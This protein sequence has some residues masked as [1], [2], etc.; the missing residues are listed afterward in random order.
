[1]APTYLPTDNWTV[2]WKL[3]YYLFGH[4]QFLILHSV[5]LSQFRLFPFPFFTYWNLSPICCDLLFSVSMYLKVSAELWSQ[6]KEGRTNSASTYFYMYVCDL[7]SFCVY[8]SNGNKVLSIWMCCNYSPCL[9]SDIFCSFY[10][11]KE[12]F[13][14]LFHL[15]ATLFKWF[16]L[17]I[18]CFVP[19]ILI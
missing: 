14:P 11:S 10:G 13:Y 15:Y 8:T 19:Y 3:E 2:F 1:M 16:S 9:H 12:Y 5:I 6:L 7:R 4:L 17:W 18:L